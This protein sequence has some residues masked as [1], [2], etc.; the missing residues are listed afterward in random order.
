MYT[1]VT[2]DS[3]KKQIVKSFCDPNGRLRIVVSTVAFGMGLDC[4]NVKEIIH[5]GPSC[6]LVN[7]IQET[8]RGGRNGELCLATILFARAD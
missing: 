1:S 3:V 6:E 4:P 2:V 7:Y 5:W 8:G